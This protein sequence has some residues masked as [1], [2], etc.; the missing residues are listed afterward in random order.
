MDRLLEALLLPEPEA[1]Q[2]W[3]EWRATQD[4]GTLPYTSQQLFPTLIP[5][6]PEW[7]EDDPAAAILKG[8]VRQAWSQNQLRL[9]KAV[10]LDALLT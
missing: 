6:F 1:R 10:E 4:I 5:A 7:L 3:A 8:V 2:A 9:R